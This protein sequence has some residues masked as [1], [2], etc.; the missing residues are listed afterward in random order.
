MS[1]VILTCSS[2]FVDLALNEVRRA[3]PDVTV[4]QHLAPGYVLL[5]TSC[6]FGKFTAPWQGQL[7]I[8]LHHLFPVHAVLPLSA[9]PDDLMQI[10]QAVQRLVPSSATVQA[11]STV[12]T[13]L[14]YSPFEIEQFV[15]E[16]QTV[17]SRTAPTERILSILITQ[18]PSDLCAYLGVSWASQNL[19]CWT[20]G[21]IPF[22]EPVSNR[23]GFK[24]LEALQVFSIRLRQGD[25]ALDLGAAPGAWTTLLRARGLRVTAVAPTPLYPWLMLDKDVIYHPI[26]AEEFLSCCQTTFDLIV[27]DMKL[28]AQDSARLMVDY[29]RHLRREGIAIMTLKLRDRNQQRIMDH[30]FRILRKAYKIIRVRQLVSNKQ[31]VTL[32]LR[33]KT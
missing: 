13:E 29:A 2:H 15:N 1:R 22:A 3:H 25:Q 7:P 18:E 5:Q 23:A 20:G 17:Y 4:I 31:E 30:S 6:S 16:K 28:D 9:T 27:N 19:S 8:Y 33:R 21:Q 11:R 26:R 14:P 10:K 32:F 12:E 24:L